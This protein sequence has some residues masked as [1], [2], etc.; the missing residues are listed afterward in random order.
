MAEHRVRF[1]EADEETVLMPSSRSVVETLPALDFRFADVTKISQL[2]KGSHGEV[3]RASTKDWGEVAMKILNSDGRGFSNVQAL[4]FKKEI[5]I[6]RGLHH[7][8]IVR[9]F[10]ASWD[11]KNIYIALEL[12]KGGTLEQRLHSGGP[13]FPSREFWD[14]ALQVA[15]GMFY[16]H[17]RPARTIIHHDLKPSNILLKEVIQAEEG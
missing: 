15:S 1:E 12:A 14:I 16:L 11:E 7:Q 2:G 13:L 3:W 9:F 4:S 6:L 8:N 17:N 10:G 5:Q